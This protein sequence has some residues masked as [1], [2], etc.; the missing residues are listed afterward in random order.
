MFSFSFWFDSCSFPLRWQLE[1]WRAEVDERKGQIVRTIHIESRPQ[2]Y[3]FDFRFRPT[4]EERW[5][6]RL[7]ISWIQFCHTFLLEN[8]SF[9]R[10]NRRNA[11]I[12]L[13]QRSVA[14]AARRVEV[15]HAFRSIATDE[16]VSLH[17]ENCTCAVRKSRGKYF[18][19]F[20]L[21]LGLFIKL[22]AL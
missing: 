10:F 11:A 1:I 9:C 6:F 3:Y 18:I 21:A 2:F 12:R 22:S 5:V 13:G 4:L 16:F 20:Q 8:C 7:T 19:D 14:K 15:W 17:K